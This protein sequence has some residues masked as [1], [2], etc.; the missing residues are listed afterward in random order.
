MQIPG[1]NIVYEDSPIIISKKE[2]EGI[3]P[4]KFKNT[5]VRIIKY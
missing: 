4:L 1:D 3:Q 2:E 5:K